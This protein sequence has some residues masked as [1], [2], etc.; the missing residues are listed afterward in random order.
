MKN[1]LKRIAAYFI[2]ILL[3][4][5]LVQGLTSTT[6]LN[7]N[8]NNYKKYTKEYNEKYSNY[9]N[10]TINLQKYYED[11]K[12]TEKEYN[13]LIDKYPYYK[14]QIEKYYKDN[15]ISKKNMEKLISATNKDFS[16]TTKKL[17]YQIEKNSLSEIIIYL[18][19][20]IAYFVGFNILTNGQ[21]LG[22][23][24]M[25]LKIK[26]KTDESQKV[27]ALQYIIRALPMYQ[28][29]YYLVRLISINTLNETN[30][31]TI[32]SGASY[33]QNI[34]DFIILTM[35]LVSKDGRGLHDIISN[36]KVITCTKDTKEIK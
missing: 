30:F 26:N 11:E 19:L 32:T 1:I 34:L 12:I 23:K 2:D 31:L 3:I 15:N 18:T 8:L 6:V 25:H 10:Y 36:T 21:T 7:P 17:Y 33:F 28:I 9:L 24:I 14:E 35:I 16:K 29:I 27:S 5:M 22:K 4:T 13:N 20:V